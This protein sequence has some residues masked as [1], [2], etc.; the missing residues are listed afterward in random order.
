MSL[1]YKKKHV[2]QYA[3]R[4]FIYVADILIPE[5]AFYL[6]LSLPFLLI[7]TYL[8]YNLCTLIALPTY[9]QK[10]DCYL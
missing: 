6:L 2:K 1:S 9:P 3:F 5:T 10:C 4:R 8:F 7:Y